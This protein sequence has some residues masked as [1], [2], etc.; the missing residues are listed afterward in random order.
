[1]FTPRLIVSGLLALAAAV[2]APSPAWAERECKPPSASEYLVL[3][4]SLSPESQARVKRNITGGN[5]SSVCR[6]LNYTV[7]RVGGFSTQA[8]ADAWGKYLRETL[9]MPTFVVRPGSALNAKP[10]PSAPVAIAPPVQ[11]PVQPPMTASPAIPSPQPPQPSEPP[12]AAAP[13][14]GSG[15]MVF[16]TPT[17]NAPARPAQPAGPVVRV[18]PISPRPAPQPANLG[19]PPVSPRPAESSSSP[20]PNPSPSSP[21]PVA[22]SLPPGTAP[23]FNPLPL[24]SGYAVLV[25][26]MNQPE[27]ANQVRQVVAR[28]VGLVAYGQRPYLLA[29]YTRDPEA[30]KA[31]LQAL[32]ERG[33]LGV[34]VDSQ[35]VMLLRQVVALQ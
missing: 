10:E 19:L 27:L 4:V 12:P 18:P 35:Q 26:F 1:M 17:L 24:G 28:D 9:G 2:A 23:T 14:S 30:A 8:G 33:F 20:V 21:S 5:P 22:A 6:Y 15:S 29:L 25:D 7:T 11:P 3:V 13:T 31:M 32:A 34:M 16:G